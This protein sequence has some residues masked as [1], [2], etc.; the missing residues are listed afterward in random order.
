MGGSTQSQKP[1][2]LNCQFQF[3]K[4][5]IKK[6]PP[7]PKTRNSYFGTRGEKWRFFLSLFWPEETFSDFQGLF[8]FSEGAALSP[9]RKN[10]NVR[11]IQKKFLKAKKREKNKATFSRRVSNQ[12][13]F[14]AREKKSE[15]FYT[16]FFRSCQHER[17]MA[18]IKKHE[19][20][21]AVIKN[22]RAKRHGFRSCSNTRKKHIFLLSFLRGKT[23]SFYS[24]IE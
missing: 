12:T 21:M 14:Y 18:V 11:G 13:L 9:P 15:F 24:C 22:R 20:K 23:H 8:Y 6:G 17:K 10:K 2:Y 7:N 3:L 19:R 1:C 5:K 4:K 16:A